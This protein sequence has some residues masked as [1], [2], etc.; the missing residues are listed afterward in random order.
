[1]TKP[2]AKPIT[3]SHVPGDTS[4][5]WPKKVPKQPARLAEMSAYYNDGNAIVPEPAAE[6]IAA[7]IET[8]EGF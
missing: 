1:M 5:I 4:T 8:R 6:F 2:H 7:V 3:I